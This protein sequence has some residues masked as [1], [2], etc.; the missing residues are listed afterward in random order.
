MLNKLIHLL[1]ELAGSAVSTIGVQNFNGDWSQ[2]SFGQSQGVRCQM[3]MSFLLVERGLFKVWVHILCL[4]ATRLLHDFFFV[5]SRDLQDPFQPPLVLTLLN[6]ERSPV[7]C[8]LQ[9]IVSLAA[10]K[11]AVFCYCGLG[12]MNR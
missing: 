4:D 8:A 7:T 12:V 6:A 5:A 11:A 2:L 1:L 10:G 9:Y 3:T